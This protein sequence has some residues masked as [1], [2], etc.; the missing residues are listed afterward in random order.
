MEIRQAVDE[1]LLKRH[2]DEDADEIEVQKENVRK[3]EKLKK[4]LNMTN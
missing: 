4:D 1:E 2:Q 3:I